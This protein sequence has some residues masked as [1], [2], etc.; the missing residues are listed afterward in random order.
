MTLNQVGPGRWRKI[1]AY[2]W[3]PSV[4]GFVDEF[5]GDARVLGGPG[6][7]LIA[8]GVATVTSVG[9]IL[10]QAAG[11]DELRM[12]LEK[13]LTQENLDLIVTP[14]TMDEELRYLVQII[15]GTLN[16]VLHPDFERF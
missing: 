2:M 10:F 16:R 6:F 1:H 15:A 14:K 13:S 11:N 5:G 9:A 3:G 12:K 4:R 8:V 7:E